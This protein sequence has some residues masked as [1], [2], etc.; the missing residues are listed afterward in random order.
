M[1]ES[2][3]LNAYVNP[4][5]SATHV[6]FQYID[7]Q[8]RANVTS[9][10]NIG[11]T[12]QSV[13]ITANG[14]HPNMTYSFYVVAYNAYGTVSGSTYYFTTLPEPPSAQTQSATPTT[15]NSATLNGV[16]DPKN[17]ATTAFFQYGPT[18]SY[19]NETTHTNCG[20]TSTNI[21]FIL[22]GLSAAATYHY[23]L[24]AS[25]AFGVSYGGDLTFT[26]LS[27]PARLEATFLTNSGFRILLHTSGPGVYA[28][29][30]TS[31]FV[32]WDNI[33]MYQDPPEPTEVID[34]LAVNSPMRFYR[35]YQIPQ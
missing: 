12:A 9:F 30:G 26:T 27:P 17:A 2:A 28:V 1:G 14:L 11:L 6:G 10:L 22:T 24:V 31:D 23:Q 19:G 7:S 34:W 18:D 32:N 15:A 20:L 4:N 8:G 16:V 5:G 3:E 25:N 29:D 21:T 35:A 33:G 13:S